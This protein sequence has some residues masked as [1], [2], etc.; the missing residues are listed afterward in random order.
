MPEV[1]Y[2]LSLLPSYSIWYVSPH[3]LSFSLN[4]LHDYSI[5]LKYQHKTTTPLQKHQQKSSTQH[6]PF[7]KIFL[8]I[9]LTF[10]SLGMQVHVFAEVVYK[11]VF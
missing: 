6:K 1:R 4:H 10:L 7:E 11:K 5:S 9:H 8:N 3:V 2:M